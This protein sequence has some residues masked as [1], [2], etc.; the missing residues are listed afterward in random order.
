MHILLACIIVL[1]I[2][3][4]FTYLQMKEVQ[5]AY[6]RALQF[7]EGNLVSVGKSRAMFKKG[8]IA[9]L[10]TDTSGKMEYAEILEGFTILAKFKVPHDLI[11]KDVREVAK[12][13]EN[14]ALLQAI[15][16]LVEELDR[17]EKLNEQNKI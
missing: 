17:G 15:G 3:N 10:S 8:T 16:F 11:G 14:K 4:V 6:R 7:K 1:V 2:N 5:R 12:I 9:I 13:T